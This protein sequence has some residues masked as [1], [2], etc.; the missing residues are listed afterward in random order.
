MFTIDAKCYADCL[1]ELAEG[2][3]WDE[4]KQRLLWVDIKRNQV[5]TREDS[6]TRIL[7]NLA[8]NIGCMALRRNG[9]MILGLTSG[10]YLLDPDGKYER[11][12]VPEL[13]PRVRFNDGKCD[14]QG[15]FWAG[16][17]HLFPEESGIAALYCVLPDGRIRRVLDGV[18][19]SNGLAFA[20]GGQTLYYIDTPTR[21]V[22]AFDVETGGDGFP[23]LKNRRTVIR[24]PDDMGYPDGMTIDAD[25]KLWIAHWGIGQVVCWDPRRGE[26]LGLARV[27][28]QAVSSCCFGGED[29][30]TLF[31][32]TARE[33]MAASE[34]ER[35][36]NIYSARLD[37][38]GAD[39]YRFMG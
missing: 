31:I 2:P 25:G 13:S 26:A 8:Q 1:C 37:V 19:N 7:C 29:M 35:A 28:V 30:K 4:R 9:G 38:S 27:P 12:E 24:V 36:G 21:R 18:S 11:L 16:T 22:D 3:V 33:D 34:A 23:I 5:L 6:D 15:R 39:S 14:P 17:I 32:T 20:D 10:I